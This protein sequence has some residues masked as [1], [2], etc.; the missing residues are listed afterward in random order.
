MKCS[1]ADCGRPYAAKGFC[2]KHYNRWRRHGD[3]THTEFFMPRTETLEERLDAL[4]DKSGGAAACWEYQCAPGSGG[5]T[6]LMIDGRQQ[7]IHRWAYEAEHGPIPQGLF[8]LH[9]C[10]NRR[11]ANPA[12]LRL[13]THQDNMDDKVARDRCYRGVGEENPGAKLTEVDVRQMRARYAAGESRKSL[14]RRFRTSRSNVDLIVTRRRWAR[15]GNADQGAVIITDG[16][17]A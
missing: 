1:V 14:A 5:Y 13:G 7:G 16:Q 17:V 11:C 3:P 8:V 15:V 9:S 2:H 4:L 10:D 12:H 6:M